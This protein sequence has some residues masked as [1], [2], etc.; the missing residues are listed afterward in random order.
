MKTSVNPE[1]KRH[2]LRRVAGG[3][4]GSNFKTTK[5]C[6]H[7]YTGASHASCTSGRSQHW[8]ICLGMELPSCTVFLPSEQALIKEFLESYF[9]QSDRAKAYP[10][11][12]ELRSTSQSELFYSEQSGQ[13]LLDQPNYEDL[14]YS[15]AWG[16]TNLRAKGRDSCPHEPA[17]S[18]SKSTLTCEG[19][20]TLKMIKVYES[21]ISQTLI[22]SLYTL[23][24]V[25]SKFRV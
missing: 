12:S 8:A 15:L 9:N 14:E 13:Y 22:K 10:I 1:E 16:Q 4:L 5:S 7:F 25:F 11:Q 21:F 18:D 20:T 23:K 3:Y 6:S 2:L 17:P 19:P 24:P